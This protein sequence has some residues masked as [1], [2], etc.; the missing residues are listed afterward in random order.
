L[1]AL[2][3]T[4]TKLKKTPAPITGAC[5]FC[6]LTQ[7]SELEKFALTES[8]NRGMPVNASKPPAHKAIARCTALPKPLF[9]F[10]L[11][12]NSVSNSGKIKSTRLRIPLFILKLSWPVRLF[13][14]AP[15]KLITTKPEQS[16][17]NEDAALLFKKNVKTTGVNTNAAKIASAIT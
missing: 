2:A 7:R 14:S 6:N 17:K 4:D 5:T 9:A 10:P 16:A 12:N 11:V 8:L 3:Q 15:A 13:K 1:S